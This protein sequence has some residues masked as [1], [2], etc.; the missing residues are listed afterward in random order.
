MK[1]ISSLKSDFLYSSPYP[2]WSEGLKEFANLLHFE[3]LEYMA[4]I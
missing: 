2:F 1:E 3:S 4:E